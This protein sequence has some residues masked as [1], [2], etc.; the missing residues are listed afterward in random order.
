MSIATSE[1]FR[2]TLVC[3]L[4]ICL[5]P[6]AMATPWLNELHNSKFDSKSVRFISGCSGDE[7]LDLAIQ[8][9]NLLTD[10]FNDLLKAMLISGRT[11]ILFAQESLPSFFEDNESIV[12][13]TDCNIIPVRAP[14]INPYN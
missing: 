13:H 12:Y 2:V 9:C 14:P 1:R 5:T 4:V 7:D 6:T 3:L 8:K 11:L 10:C